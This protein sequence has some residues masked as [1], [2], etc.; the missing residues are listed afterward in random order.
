MAD[1]DDLILRARRRLNFETLTAY[2]GDGS[3]R[4]YSGDKYLVR[5]KLA[6]GFSDPFPVA[7]HPNANL[8]ERDGLPVL[9]GTDE[10]GRD[11]IL[12]AH[13]D[14]AGVSG[15][16][17]LIYNPLSNAAYGTVDSAKLTPFLWRAHPD[18]TGKPF[19]VYVVVPLV[20][21]SS[22][23]IYP[24]TLEIDLASFVP[25][26]GDHRFACVFWK[27]D[28]T[29]AAYA[30]STRHELDPLVESDMLEC[31][32]AAPADAVP[33]CG[34]V[35]T[36]GETALSKRPD[37][38]FD[39][40]QFVNLPS[41]GSGGGTVTSVGLSAPS[42]LL[43]VGGSP[44]T[45]SGTLT[46]SK[47]TDT[48]ANRV[49]AS[50][51]GAAGAAAFR[52]LAGDDLPVVPI[53]KGGTGQTTASAAFGALS[54]LTTKGDLLGHNGTTSVR[55]GTGSF[56]RGVLA[57]NTS[58]PSGFI[59]HDFP[60]A[61]IVDRKAQNTAG[62]ASV[63]GSWQTRDLNTLEANEDTI[64]T[65]SGS[66]FQLKKGRYYIHIVSPFVG[67]GSGSAFVRLRL[68][69]NGFAE[70][71]SHNVTSAVVGTPLV[72]ELSGVLIVTDTNDLFTVQYYKSTGRP[73]NGLGVQMN[74]T[75]EFERYTIV[76]IVQLTPMA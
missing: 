54:P 51:D 15:T 9:I 56:E 61:R 36:G 13:Y 22:S 6:T 37:K 18:E 39:M 8:P 38:S 62:G 40:R 41:G 32:T 20:L 73:T 27:T 70:F 46:L 71:V 34:W 3:G 4:I 60:W 57:I 30:S 58:E 66:G 11:V 68:A 5:L 42:D 33:I 21:L 43:A 26:A 67:A 31:V 49:Y 28:N 53:S 44:I 65:M 52:A 16:S 63:A 75:G 17:S 48:P 50:P 2:L 14:V 47:P 76:T 10:F 72:V 55:F 29:L 35:L 64:V 74:I 1:L 25:A 59:W 23:V 45:T 24:V 69:R 7:A 12:R 19:T